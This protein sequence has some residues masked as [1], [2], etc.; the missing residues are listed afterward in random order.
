[1][2]D[3]VTVY[4]PFQECIEVTPPLGVTVWVGSV[5]YS[6]LG[7]L[8]TQAPHFT[9]ISFVHYQCANVVH[10][11]F[12][13]PSMCIYIIWGKTEIWRC[14]LQPQVSFWLSRFFFP[15]WRLFFPDLT[16]DSWEWQ[17]TWGEWERGTSHNKD[18]K[19]EISWGWPHGI[20]PILLY[21]CDALHWYL[22]WTKNPLIHS[23]KR[24]KNLQAI[25]LDVPAFFS[26]Q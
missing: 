23:S 4:K 2:D 16:V 6:T 21:H 22:I 15:P 1:M 11:Y 12:M 9:N 17:L 20:H 8:I 19:P 14:S 26:R 13:A 25:K 3:T 10:H 18:P 7:E 5:K 24:K